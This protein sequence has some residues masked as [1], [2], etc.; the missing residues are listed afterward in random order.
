MIALV[1]GSTGFV[2]GWLCRVLLEQGWQVRAFRRQNSLLQQLNGLAVDHYIGDL[3]QP[4]SLIPAVQGVD[5]VFHAA[6]VLGNNVPDEKRMAVTVGGTRDLLAAASKAGVSRFVHIS[7]VAALGVPGMTPTGGIPAVMD[8]THTWNELPEHWKY[9][10]SK[11]LAELEVQKAVARGLDAVIVNPG[12]ILGARDPYR[13]SSSILLRLKEKHLPFLVEGGLNL[14]H[15][16]DVVDGILAACREGKTGERYIL[17]DQNWT[18]RH[19][20]QTAAEILQVEAPSVT[21]PSGLVRS[22]AGISQSLARFL[23]IPVNTELFYQAG[24]YFYVT[25]EKAR[26]ELGWQPKRTVENA[27]LEACQWFQNPAS[28]AEDISHNSVS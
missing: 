2:G 15:I 3:T 25:N 12:L 7:S 26:R 4:E 19:F 20:I 6:A 13:Q 24:G 1:T 23:D 27:I 8:E 11:Y 10:Y 21:L 16:L 5:V 28:Q 9:A 17:S 22:L 14:V 18:I